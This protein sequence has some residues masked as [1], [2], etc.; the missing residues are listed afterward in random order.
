MY[1]L[2]HMITKTH[3]QLDLA[4]A[5]TSFLVLR[6]LLA[7]EYGEAGLEKLNGTNWFAD[8]T[9]PFPFN[10]LSADISWNLALSFEI[11]GAL[12]L[13]LGLATRFISTS[14]I[15][16]TIAAIAA[17]HWPADWSS[18]SELLKGYRIIDENND[19]FG[20]YKLPLIYIVMFIPLLFNGA[21]KISI[22]YWL[23][24]NYAKNHTEN[25]S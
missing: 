15:I 16:L 24:K 21:G 2:H 14:L 1:C 20:N 6:L 8:V 9:F 5:Y 18:I 19:G 3:R 11:G 10:L 12:L 13:V 7:W 4:G 25:H 22:D 17:V 23:A